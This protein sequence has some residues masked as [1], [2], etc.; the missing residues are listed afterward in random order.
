MGTLRKLARLEARLIHWLADR[1]G[2][3]RIDFIWHLGL[4]IDYEKTADS[5][6]AAGLAD[7]ASRHRE[8]A[9]QRRSWAWECV[10][11]RTAEKWRKAA[12]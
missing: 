6:D 2:F 11:A 3:W 4:A 12:V 8:L 9:A 7:A 10:P 5:L 1:L